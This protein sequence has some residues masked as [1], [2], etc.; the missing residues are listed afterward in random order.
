MKSFSINE[1]LSI[2]LDKQYASSKA[3][4]ELIDYVMPTIDLSITERT[5]LCRMEIICKYPTLKDVDD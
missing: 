5:N 1:V 3:I 4:S 2:C